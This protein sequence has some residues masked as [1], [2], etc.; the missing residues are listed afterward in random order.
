MAI[1]KSVLVESGHPL[2]ISSDTPTVVL[3]KRLADAKQACSGKQPGKTLATGGW[4]LSGCAKYQTAY[5]Q[6]FAC[7]NI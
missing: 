1:N 2:F 7:A 3:D 4:C 6:V 5:S